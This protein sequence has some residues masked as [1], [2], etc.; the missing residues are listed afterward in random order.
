MSRI[1]L[2]EEKKVDLLD[3]IAHADRKIKRETERRAGNLLRLSDIEEEIERLKHVPDEITVTDHAIIRYMERVL[4]LTMEDLK[5]DIVSE[6][7]KAMAG[8]MQSGNFTIDGKELV[9]R[10]RAIVTIK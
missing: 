2:L 7:L 3:S 4:G 6:K 1:K 10:N 9:M 5:K 8:K